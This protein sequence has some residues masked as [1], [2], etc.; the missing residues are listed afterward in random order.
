MALLEKWLSAV[1]GILDLVFLFFPDIDN[2]HR[3]ILILS[4]TVVYLL[5][6]CASLFLKKRSI[7]NELEDV[8][9]KH[10]ALAARFKE[11]SKEVQLYKTA[12][13]EIH[14][15]FVIA[16]QPNQ[17]AKVQKIYEAFLTTRNHLIDGGNEDE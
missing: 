11:K 17:T 12:F 10:K 6:I 14:T 16:L 7:E 8:S 3:I 13:N 2:L 1:T 15:W 5:I 4:T 9:G